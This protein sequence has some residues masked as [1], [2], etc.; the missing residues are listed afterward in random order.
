M[1][2]K[3]TAKAEFLYLVNVALVVAISWVP[4]IFNSNISLSDTSLF[5]LNK[6]FNSFFSFFVY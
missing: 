5:N 3:K 6:Y 2:E 4:P 1:P